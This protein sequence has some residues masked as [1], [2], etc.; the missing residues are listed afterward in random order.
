ME[1]TITKLPVF[2]QLYNIRIIRKMEP[3]DAHQTILQTREVLN[4][5]EDSEFN[6]T[7]SYLHNHTSQQPT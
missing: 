6:S 2:Q 7:K 4:P 1:P 5:S 3:A